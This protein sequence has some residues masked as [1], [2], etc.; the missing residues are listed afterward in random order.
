MYVVY[1]TEYLKRNID[2]LLVYCYYVLPF[3][4]NGV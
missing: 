4:S 3:S 1:M 2:L